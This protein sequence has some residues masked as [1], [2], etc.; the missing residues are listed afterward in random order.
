M[1][2]AA[3]QAYKLRWPRP[4]RQR[5]RIK[6]SFTPFPVR[7]RTLGWATALL[8][9]DRR[10]YRIIDHLLNLWLLGALYRLLRP[11]ARKSIPR[12]LRKSAMGIDSVLK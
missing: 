11:A 6:A 8:L 2:E 9:R 10:G 12:F 4:A 3:K 1:I 5:Y 7:R